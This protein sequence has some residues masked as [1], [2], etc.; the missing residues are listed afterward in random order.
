[1]QDNPQPYRFLLSAGGTGGHIFPAVSVADALREKYPDASFLFIGAQGRMEMEKVPK[2]GY[3]I[4]GLNISGISRS[5]S[6][7]LLTWPFQLIGSLFKALGTIRKFKPH[8]A[9]GFGGFASGPAIYM[10]SMLG[11]PSL[12][13][14]QNSYAGVTNRI[15]AG[16]V[17]K[18]CVAYHNM[19]NFFPSGK[20][21]KTGNPVR[22][23]ISEFKNTHEEGLSHFDLDASF[24][25]LFV[26]GG[27]QGALAINN[28]VYENL[29]ELLSNK[30]Q[31]IWQCGRTFFDK[32]KK[33]VEEKKME[34]R[35]KVFEFIYEMDKAYAAADMIVSRAG[36][37]S[38]SELSLVGKPVIFVP[39]PTAAEDH[40]TK[41]AMA[42]VDNDAALMVKNSEVSSKLTEMVTRIRNEEG[43][44][45]KLSKNISEMA[46]DDATERIV[47]EI[48]NILKT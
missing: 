34:D 9:M 17:K 22:K 5:L 24:P 1:M 40:Q 18:V 21:V 31:I 33:L 35:V 12:I 41:N 28:A 16:K 46:I 6:L 10:A 29:D 7:K 2:A 47:E 4:V 42:L 36:A 26:F 8:I 39:L 11:V 38:I 23:V 25:V 20:V 32:A 30:L 15:L 43:L 19:E 37:I 44:S 13:Q 3:D 48:E 27:S 14:E 45:D